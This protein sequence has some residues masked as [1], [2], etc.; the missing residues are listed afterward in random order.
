[1]SPK[2]KWIDA[3][4]G[5]AIILVVIMHFGSRQVIPELASE[6]EWRTSHHIAIFL[7]LFE[8]LRMPLFFVISGALA[9]SMI[10]RPWKTLLVKRA[11]GM[12]YV[13]LIW[14]TIHTFIYFAAPARWVEPT[15]GRWFAEATYSLTNLWYLYALAVLYPLAKLLRKALL[16]A[17][18]AA[19]LIPLALPAGWAGETGML[20][21]VPESAG[22]FL[23][24]AAIAGTIKSL[25]AGRGTLAGGVAATALYGCV[26]LTQLH[27]ANNAWHLTA[28]LIGVTAACLMLR[29]LESASPK[30]LGPFEYLGRNTIVIY[31]L[32]MPI[33]YYWISWVDG[34][35][36]SGGSWGALAYILGGSAVIL[37]VSLGLGLALRSVAPA[38]FLWPEK[39]T[40]KVA[41]S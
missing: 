36:L 33:I 34:A 37:G 13:Y 20:H 26:V 31:V 39:R 7:D 12:Y 3:A 8:P 24:G 17:A 21:A 14:V 30:L 38:L 22:W 10:T 4:K 32:H 11:W 40:A 19:L 6:E 16:P 27:L 29:A 2:L 5:I 41:V 25:P 18:V 23:L 35:G 9:S 28:S 1:M 15:V